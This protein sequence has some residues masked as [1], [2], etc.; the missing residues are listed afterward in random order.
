M[1]CFKAIF[2]CS[3]WCCLLECVDLQ[4]SDSNNADNSVAGDIIGITPAKP[5]YSGFITSNYCKSLR[6][7]WFGRGIN[8]IL[9]NCFKKNNYCKFYFKTSIVTTAIMSDNRDRKGL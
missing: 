9:T 4:V 1:L 5:R 3:N 7:P 2:T 6:I 8:P